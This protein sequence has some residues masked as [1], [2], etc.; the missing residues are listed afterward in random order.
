MDVFRV[1]IKPETVSY[2]SGKPSYDSSRGYSDNFELV[3]TANVNLGSASRAIEILLDKDASTLFPSI[4]AETGT[5]YYSD[6]IRELSFYFYNDTAIEKRVTFNQTYPEMEDL[7]DELVQVFP[8]QG[9][10]QWLQ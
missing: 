2:F 9:L 5:S 7:L 4:S 1:D 8:N 10:E 3:G 6:P